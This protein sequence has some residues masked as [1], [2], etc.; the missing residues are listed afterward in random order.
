[1]TNNDKPSTE[2]PRVPVTLGHVDRAIRAMKDQIDY[3]PDEVTMK[4][5]M[6]AGAIIA[7]MEAFDDH[8]GMQ[9]LLMDIVHAVLGNYVADWACMN[10]GLKPPARS[11]AA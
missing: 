10:Y 4:E 8:V 11:K 6:I 2:L 7:N 3:L 1:M 9:S 5:A